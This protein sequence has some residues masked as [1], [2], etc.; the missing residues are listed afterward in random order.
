MST[1]AA[2]DH[3]H[4]ACQLPADAYW[5]LIRT[6]RLTL[7]PPLTDSPEDLTRRDHAVIARIAA[8]A[9]ANAAEADLAAQFVAASEHQM[10]RHG[11]HPDSRVFVRKDS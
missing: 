4:L 9:P 1:D 11:R 7:P 2:P 5:Q 6:L 10:R 8:L 3:P